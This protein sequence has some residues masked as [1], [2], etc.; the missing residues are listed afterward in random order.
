MECKNTILE[1][2]FFIELSSKFSLMTVE[3]G[4]TETFEE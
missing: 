4:G 1:L 2:I 3:F